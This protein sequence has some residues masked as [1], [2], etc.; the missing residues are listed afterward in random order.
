MLS[1]IHQTYKNIEYIIIDGGSTD[2]T[3]D[4]IK[5]YEKHLAYWISEPDKGIYDAMNKGIYKATGEWINF[6]NCGDWFYNE[7]V[8]D[9]IKKSLQEN[10]DVI[11]G[12][13]YGDRIKYRT[14][15]R[16][17]LF[18]NIGICHQCIF[19]RKH[20]LSNGFDLRYKIIADFAWL[21]K[22]FSQQIKIKSI[23]T[24]IAVYEREGVSSVYLKLVRKE[25][26]EIMKEYFPMWAVVLRR[27]IWDIRIP[28]LR[29]ILGKTLI[30]RIRN[31][32]HRINTSI[33]K[34]L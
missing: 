3:V 15:N 11:C 26:F 22:S 19:A 29:Y 21:M 10:F 13:I 33:N 25:T 14:I 34:C 18:R 24:I 1:V 8:I 30:K 27:F 5:K 20:I 28:L 17:Y 23:N 32:K 12:Y 31:L 7:H 4:I 2:G 9:E 6:M 16:Y